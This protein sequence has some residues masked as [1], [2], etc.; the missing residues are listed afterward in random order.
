MDYRVAAELK[1]ETAEMRQ[2]YTQTMIALAERDPRIVLLDA[3]LMSA[4]GTK[5]FAARFPGRSINCGVQEANMIGVAAGM[6]AAGKVPFTHTFAPFATRRAC[7]QVFLSGAYARLNVKMIGSDPGITAALNGGTHMPFEDLGIMRGI[8][9]MTV[10]EPTDGTMLADLLPKVADAYGMYY[11]RL[12]RR[13]TTKIFEDGSTFTIGKAAQLREGTDL[14]IIAIGFCVA[15]SLKAAQLLASAGIQA[16][17]L[18][19][20]TLKP[21]DREAIV[22]AALETGA[23]VTAENHNIINGLGSAVAEVLAQEAPAPLEMVGVHDEFGE[24]GQIDYLSRRFGLLAENIVAAAQK[25][26]ARKAGRA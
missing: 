16:R 17:V 2:T 18:N 1:P 25:A 22:R 6:S 8:P 12:H 11:L 26:L 9:T 14:T 7:D 21:V 19:M 15:E 4:A 20:F 5:S 23:L 24:V 13:V 10:I 3:D